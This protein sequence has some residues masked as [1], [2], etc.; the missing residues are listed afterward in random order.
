MTEKLYAVGQRECWKLG[1]H[2]TRNS[3]A[4]TAEGLHSKADIAAELGVRDAEIERLLAA[5]HDCP[6]CGQPH[7]CH[8]VSVRPAD[9]PSARRCEYVGMYE[10]QC[11]LDVGHAGTHKIFGPHTFG[12][13]TLKAAGPTP[14][15]V[16]PRCGRN[17]ISGAEECD[18]DPTPEHFLK[19]GYR[20][21]KSGDK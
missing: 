4:M 1:D 12:G 16:C 6:K 3:L 5:V 18:C 13:D 14:L 8:L 7:A 19:Q 9:E 15:R 10:V 2:Y 21:G 20:S 11:G 17:W